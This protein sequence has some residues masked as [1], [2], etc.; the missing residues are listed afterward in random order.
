MKRQHLIDEMAEA[1]LNGSVVYIQRKNDGTIIAEANAKG[2]RNAIESVGRDVIAEIDLT[3]IELLDEDGN[4]TDDMENAIGEA[5]YR[6]GEL[7]LDI[8]FE[9]A[10]E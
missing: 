1:I 9:P 4:V 6:L 3:G 8:E 7:D 2:L 10:G 5:E